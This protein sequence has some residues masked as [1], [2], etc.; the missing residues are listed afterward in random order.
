ML[1]DRRPP[2]V[3]S[4]PPADGVPSS[5]STSSITNRATSRWNGNTAH[6]RRCRDLFKSFLK[7]AGDPSEPAT[8]AAI[9]ALVEQ[10]VIAEQARADCLAEGGLTKIGLELVIRAENLANRTLKRLKLDKVTASTK[11][12]SMRDRAEAAQ[13][14]MNA[15]AAP[16]SQQ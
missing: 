16:E 15:S 12:K 14:A 11:G 9:T 6:G 3:A 2:A 5:R 1:S 4:R 13:R 7:Q 8:Q 10:I